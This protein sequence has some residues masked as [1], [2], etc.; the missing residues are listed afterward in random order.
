[1]GSTKFTLAQVRIFLIAGAV[2]LILLTYFLVFNRNLQTTNQLK[3]ETEAF[4]KEAQEYEALKPKVN[5][6]E[7]FTSRYQE[8]M[9]EFTLN[10]PVKLTQQKSIYSLYR[11]QIQSGIVI[12]SV[13]P[14][15]EVPFYYKGNPVTTTADQ[16]NAIKEI[17]AEEQP[18]SEYYRADSIDK[19]IGS[20]NTYTVTFTGSVK[21]VYKAMDWVTENKEKLSI[22]HIALQFD[23]STGGLNGTMDVNFYAMLGNGVPYVEPNL[24]E[25]KYGID[26]DIFG[27]FDSKKK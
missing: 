6:L 10:F 16:E 23:P 14:G 27:S 11:M 20:V 25:F 7:I 13:T 4:N 19:M 12:Q 18:I 1:M 9:E 26:G 17:D 21:E 3:T 8:Q 2:V 5:D 15:S 22:G 24:D